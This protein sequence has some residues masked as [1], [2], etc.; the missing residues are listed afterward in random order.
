[1]CRRGRLS[2]WER[3]KKKL[4]F[5]RTEGFLPN[6]VVAF[7][8]VKMDST[9]SVKKVLALTLAR[10]PRISVYCKLIWVAIWCIR[11]QAYRHL[12][13]DTSIRHNKNFLSLNEVGQHEIMIVT[14]EWGE[15]VEMRV[16]I[17]GRHLFTCAANS[18]LISPKTS[19]RIVSNCSRAQILY[20]INLILTL[21]WWKEKILLMDVRS[22][23]WASPLGIRTQTGEKWKG[24]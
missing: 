22:R 6:S 8:F 14:A 21:P 24:I 3:Q 2:A 23:G 11:I 19:F 5:S 17:C 7:G 4:S 16:P 12:V 1:M 9:K 10:S 13:R 20:K 18:E 15:G